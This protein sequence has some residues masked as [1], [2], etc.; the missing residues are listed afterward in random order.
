MPRESMDSVRREL[1][2]TRERHT[3]ELAKLR[4]DHAD[5]LA[6]SEQT[7]ALERRHNAKLEAILHVVRAAL[8]QALPGD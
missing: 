7:L 6:R 1:R 3:Y 8:E 5:E 4:A 2:E